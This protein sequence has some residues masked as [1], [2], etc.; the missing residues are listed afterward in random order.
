MKKAIL[1]LAL[2][3]ALVLSGCVQPQAPEQEKIPFVAFSEPLISLCKVDLPEATVNC[4]ST[5]DDP[6]RYFGL[7]PN[8]F[9]DETIYAI[10][11]PNLTL[12]ECEL[13]SVSSISHPSLE[14]KEFEKVILTGRK[15]VSAKL[16]VGLSDYWKNELKN[17][18]NLT[19]SEQTFLFYFNCKESTAY[20]EKIQI[21]GDLKVEDE[22]WLF[23]SDLLNP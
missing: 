16:V 11:Q 18:E 5:G 10:I 6:R 3:F 7:N 2:V 1:A 15:P 21:R 20:S 14:I 4:G 19:N 22:G 9:Q 17:K 8:T 13:S 12:V 23:Q